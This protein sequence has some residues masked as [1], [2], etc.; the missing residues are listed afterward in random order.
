[1]PGPDANGF[2]SQQNIGFNLWGP[3]NFTKREK[4]VMHLR[5]SS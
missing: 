3:T 5:F 1:M 4:N 2:V